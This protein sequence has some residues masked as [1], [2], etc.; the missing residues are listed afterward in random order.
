MKWFR[1]TKEDLELQL[2]TM[3]AKA[4]HLRAIVNASE[5]C[6]WYMVDNLIEL[7]TNVDVLKYKI[8]NFKD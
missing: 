6:P 1:K 3:E 4:K 8:E 7:Q 5:S 2:V